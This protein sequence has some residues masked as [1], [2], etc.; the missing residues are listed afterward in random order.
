MIILKTEQDFYTSV[1]KALKEIDPKFEDYEGMVI[2][3]SHS[4]AHVEDNIKKIQW[5]RENNIPTLGICMGMQLMAIEW[6]RNKCAFVSA[7]STEIDPSTPDPVVIKFPEL[8]VGIRPVRWGQNTRMESH[9]H[10]YYLNPKYKKYFDGEGII[11]K[12]EWVTSETD[13]I[14]EVMRLREHPF[15]CG[16]QFHPEYQ[17]SKDNPHPLLKEFIKACKQK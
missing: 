9:W 6:C 4:P 11:G 8:R 1:M 14:M 17:S 3:G 16:I 12:G 15:F 13:G 5:A 7:N 2:T 10:N